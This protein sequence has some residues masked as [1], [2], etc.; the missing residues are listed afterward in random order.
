MKNTKFLQVALALAMLLTSQSTFSENYVVYSIVQELPMGEENETVKKNFYVN[1]GSQQGVEKGTTLNVFRVV[2]RLDP[3]KTKQRFNYRVK[4]GELSVLHSED[5][6]A[7]ARVSSFLE[8]ENVPL[9]EI[10]N[11][12]I[13]DRVGVKID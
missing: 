10:K 11:I 3:Y 1:V 13:G 12:M 9:F 6:S 4:I 7:I 2:S 8:G 5:N